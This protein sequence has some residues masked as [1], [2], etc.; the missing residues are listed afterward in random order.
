MDLPMNLTSLLTLSHSQ[1][2]YVPLTGSIRETSL[3]RNSPHWKFSSADGLTAPE[4]PKCSRAYNASQSEVL[5]MST[6]ID[7]T[8]NIK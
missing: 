5:K 7:K 8:V 1:S 3:Y 4:I 2:P 6:G